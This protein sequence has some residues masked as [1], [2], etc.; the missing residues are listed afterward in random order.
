MIPSAAIHGHSPHE[1]CE[2]ASAPDHTSILRQVRHAPWCVLICVLFAI[3]HPLLAASPVIEPG[4][5]WKTLHV[6]PEQMSHAKRHVHALR[7]RSDITLLFETEKIIQLATLLEPALLI[8]HHESVIDF[9]E[10]HLPTKTVLMLKPQRAVE[11]IFQPLREEICETHPELSRLA[12]DE[13]IT[14]WL[15]IAIATVPTAV[16]TSVSLRFAHDLALPV[17]ALFLKAED[18]G[19][20]LT[21]LYDGVF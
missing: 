14:R 15:P 21:S 4:T 20:H 9:P 12:S 13:A 3:P 1:I 7:T 5:P 19:C 11:L 8:A 10:Y 16:T 18:E 17:I 6:S 2:T